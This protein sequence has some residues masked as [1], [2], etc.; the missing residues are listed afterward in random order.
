MRTIQLL[1]NRMIPVLG[2]GTWRMGESRSKRKVEIESLRLGLDLGMSLI[3]TA[4]MYADGDAEELVGEA[5]ED[6]R[7]ETFLVSKV[8]PQHASYKGTIQAC[9]RSLGRLRT[10]YLDLYLLHWQGNIPLTETLEAF[11]YLKKAGHI[12][13]YGVSNFDQR[14]M[15]TAIHLPGGSEIVTDQ[16]LYNLLHRGIEFDLLP[17]SRTRGIVIMAYSPIEHSPMDQSNML[18]HPQIKLIATEHEVTPAQVVLA[19]LLHQD[20]VVIPK[21][22]NPKHVRENYE[23][24]D[25]VLSNKDL[26]RIEKAFPRPRRKMALEVK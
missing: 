16:V 22:S 18:E 17:W 23:A 24:L 20:V 7:S 15:Q 12:L 25:L 13:D 11:Q 4:E 3:D 2:Q 19:W 10:D 26:I 8:L 5:I 14:D 1:S 6:R 9:E 21:A